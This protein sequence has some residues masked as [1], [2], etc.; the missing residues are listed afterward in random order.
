M[1]KYLVFLMVLVF[2]STPAFADFADIYETGAESFI[3]G[4]DL[5]SLIAG[6][7]SK[8]GNS[9]AAQFA[10]VTGSMETGGMQL[11]LNLNSMLQSGIPWFWDG[12][13]KGWILNIPSLGLDPSVYNDMVLTFELI[14]SDGTTTRTSGSIIS[15]SPASGIALMVGLEGLNLSSC[16]DGTL[17]LAISFTGT[18]DNFK[19]AVPEPGTLILLGLGILGTVMARFYYRRPSRQGNK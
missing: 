8:V 16:L 4:L 5:G 2:I 6:G 1:K 7:G 12:W 18:E 9:T 3:P 17:N 11:S 15:G 14:L 13:H 19:I 10:T